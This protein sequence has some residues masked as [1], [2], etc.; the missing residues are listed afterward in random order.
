MGRIE[1]ETWLNVKPKAFP[2]CGEG[3][4]H[5]R[6]VFRGEKVGRT[7]EDGNA[8]DGFGWCTQRRRGKMAQE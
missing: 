3:R 2:G 5:V 6:R 7:F 8:K 1:P 4:A